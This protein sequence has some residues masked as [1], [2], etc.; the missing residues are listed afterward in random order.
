ACSF[1]YSRVN[2]ILNYAIINRVIFKT[3]VRERMVVYN[4]NQGISWASSGVEYAQAYRADILR[5]INQQAKYIFTDLFLYVNNKIFTINIGY[6][7]NEIISLYQFITHIKIASSTYSIHKIEEKLKNKNYSK[8][9]V[10]SSITY[11]LENDKR[12]IVCH[13]RDPEKD[14]IDRV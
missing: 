3:E 10:D 9:R 2:T 7:D 1:S 4:I 5:K 6:K 8:N 12:K 14:H 11:T 13:F